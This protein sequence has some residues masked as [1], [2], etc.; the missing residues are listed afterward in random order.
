MEAA[1]DDA[2]INKAIGLPESGEHHSAH[3]TCDS[4]YTHQQTKERAAYALSIGITSCD[5]VKA[6]HCG[7][8]ES[9]T[10]SCQ[11]DRLPIVGPPAILTGAHQPAKPPETKWQ[12]SYFF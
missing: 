5:A 3:Q 9:Q 12:V 4:W 6:Q 7:V 11:E 1:W 8:K 10:H 2:C